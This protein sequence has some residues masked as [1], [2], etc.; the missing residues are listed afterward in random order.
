[1]TL[2]SLLFDIAVLA[3]FIICAAYCASRG[4]AASLLNFF[5]T[6]VSA[7]VSLFVSNK[8]SGVIFDALFRAQLEQ[9]TLSALQEAGLTRLDEVLSKVLGFLPESVA[10]LLSINHGEVMVGE[11]AQA[12]AT[13]I[14]QQVI[15]PLVVPFIAIILFIVAFLGMRLLVSFLTTLLKGVNKVPLLGAA[16][17]MLG[18]V[19]G[20]LIGA[21]YVALILGVIW[22]IDSAYSGSMFA[23]KYFGQSIVYRLVQQLGFFV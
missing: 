3:I 4:F 13:A 11:N 5:G 8:L 12:V 19:I 20:L 21:L 9:K 23:A 2:S 10:E 14:V 17:K 16:N 6:I 22:L 18:V 15:A 7:G 1:M